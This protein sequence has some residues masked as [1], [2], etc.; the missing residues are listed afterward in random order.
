[1]RVHGVEVLAEMAP[2]ARF[3]GCDLGV[4]ITPAAT[5]PAVVRRL[6]ALGIRRVI[7][8][9]GGF[10]ELDAGG[11]DLGAEL[12]RLAR[13]AGVRL[14]G[15]NC[16]GLIQLA[17]G[18]V[19]SFAVISDTFV[20]GDTAVVSQSGG[21]ALSYMRALGSQGAGVGWMASIGNKLD[22][23][24]ADVAAFLLR[25]KPIGRLVCY[26]ESVSAGRELCE[27]ARQSDVPVIVQKAGRTA[28]A[29]PI[30]ASH[31]AALAGD[32]AVIAAA[33]EQAGIIRARDTREVELA[34]HA[35][36]MPELRGDRVALLARSGGHAVVATDA[37][38]E[39]GLSLP[40]FSPELCADLGRIQP[41]TV[42][43]RT[44]PLDFGDIYDFDRMERM[45]ERIVREAGID[46]TLLVMVYNRLHEG[47]GARRLLGR[48][49][50]LS[51]SSG[52][53]I[54]MAVLTVE[55]ELAAVRRATLWP[56]FGTPEEAA[57][58]LGLSLRR[59]Q[60]RARGAGPS[61]PPPAGAGAPAQE[62][63]EPSRVWSLVGSLALVQAAGIPVAET[64]PWHKAQDGPFPLVAKHSAGS[65]EVV[66]KA[67]AG[68][69]R[70]GLTDRAALVRAAAEIAAAA[71]A[72]GLGEGE[73][74]VQPELGGVEL[75]LGA[76]RDGSFGPVVLFGCG[77]SL[78]EIVRDVVVWPYPFALAEIEHCWSRT[79]LGPLAGDRLAPAVLAPWLAGLGELLVRHPHIQEI[80]VNPVV[81]GAGGA[82]AVDARVVA[83]CPRA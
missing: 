12:G 5:V 57:H 71:R 31:T 47:E 3:A 80:D 4:V 50:E 37:C 62:P 21:V 52:K 59:H 38:A 7:V 76:K 27:A 24:E 19:A 11:A 39:E 51:R 63:A 35:T 82:Q 9:T 6:A 10:S 74:V 48:M 79:R 72:H 70:T 23:H 56:L 30:A 33:L 16:V 40:P 1:A 26:L 29:V 68:L 69:V 43:R 22:V 25:H 42:I 14:M 15:P 55:E 77:G 32:D 49:A 83:R 34:V 64:R 44:N 8:Q 45:F 78:V 46:G 2:P 28:V 75:F 20:P 81:I 17:T 58:A 18:N 53:P 65:D 67:A 60:A 73:V 61:V 66:H 41:E 13:E 36:R 54:A